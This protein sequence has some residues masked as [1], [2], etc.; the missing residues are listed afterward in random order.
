[1]RRLGQQPLD[2]HL[3]RTAAGLVAE[4]PRLDDA[5]VVEDQQI[6]GVEQVGQL[7]KDMVTCR[8]TTAVEQT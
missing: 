3:D 7:A 5:G 2:Q 8:P 1:M 4:Q 6:A